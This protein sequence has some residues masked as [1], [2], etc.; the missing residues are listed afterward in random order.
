MVI[1]LFSKS[2]G[3]DN[4]MMLIDLRNKHVNA[5]NVQVVMEEIG[6]FLNALACPWEENTTS[7]LRV[8]TPALTSRNL[9]ETDMEKVAEYLHQGTTRI[10]LIPIF[11]LTYCPLNLL[12]PHYFVILI[13]T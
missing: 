2:D 5:S 7:A 13:F 9:R 4:H 1:L 8:G 10:S 3:T 6:I 11:N 12:S